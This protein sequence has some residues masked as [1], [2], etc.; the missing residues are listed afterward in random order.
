MED[1]RGVKDIDECL[2]VP[3]EIAIIA[4]HILDHPDY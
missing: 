3:H 1:Q 4:S 2:V